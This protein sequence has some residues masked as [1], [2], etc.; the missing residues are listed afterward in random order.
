MRLV[1]QLAM[2]VSAAIASLPLLGVDV[3]ADLV[4]IY[5]LSDSGSHC[6]PISSPFTGACVS[7]KSIRLPIARFTSCHPRDGNDNDGT[8][9]SVGGCDLLSVDFCAEGDI[10]GIDFFG[11]ESD[12]K[13]DPPLKAQCSHSSTHPKL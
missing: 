7:R 5:S 12:D 2:L 9:V 10:E 4:F 11:F 13:P 3:G 6:P 8:D 1:I